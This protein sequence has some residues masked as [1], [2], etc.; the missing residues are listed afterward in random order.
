[1]LPPSSIPHLPSFVFLS[2]R[3]P[4]KALSI[5][6]DFSAFNVMKIHSLPSL[7]GNR[8]SSVHVPPRY[9]GGITALRGLLAGSL[10]RYRKDIVTASFASRGGCIVQGRFPQVLRDLEVARWGEHAD[11]G[12]IRPPS[13]GV[14]NPLYR[15]KIPLPCRGVGRD[16]QPLRSSSYCG[17]DWGSRTG[18]GKLCGHLA[19]PNHCRFP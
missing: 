5:I 15:E 7:T 8:S 4:A 16:G 9:F 14:A 3:V 1:M 18:R 17:R 2:L 13:C 6:M 11:K 19:G 10:L 12:R